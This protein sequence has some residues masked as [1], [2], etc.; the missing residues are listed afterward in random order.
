MNYFCLLP[1]LGQIS[2]LAPWLIKL[3]IGSDITRFNSVH[4]KKCPVPAA[5]VVLSWLRISS[6]CSCAHV[7]NPR[8]PAMTGSKTQKKKKTH[9]K[10]SLLPC[11]LPFLPPPCNVLWCSSSL[12]LVK[13]SFGVAWQQPSAAL[14]LQSPR[15]AV[16]LPP[17]RCQGFLFFLHG[18]AFP[19]A[20]PIFVHLFQ[21]SFFFFYQPLV[22]LFINSLFPTV[23][24][25]S[26]LGFLGS[27]CNMFCLC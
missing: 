12:D 2:S 21:L 22:C 25:T 8:L 11:S 13:R 16:R 7:R 6:L 3:V 26:T 19:S 17:E 14:S 20:L 10:N 27:S 4:T 24:R 9:K 5:L 15:S 1:L 18:R 23:H